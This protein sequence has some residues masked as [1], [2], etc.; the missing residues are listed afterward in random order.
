MVSKSL[1]YIFS[2]YFGSPPL[3]IGRFKA[4][5]VQKHSFAVKF[6]F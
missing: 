5:K 1:T 4:F 2:E 6:E 3:G